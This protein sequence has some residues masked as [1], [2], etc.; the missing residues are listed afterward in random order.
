M[1][2]AKTVALLMG[3]LSKLLAA[4]ERATASGEEARRGKKELIG[5]A[6]GIAEAAEEVTRIAKELAAACTDKRMRTVSSERTDRGQKE[7]QF[8]VL[9][10]E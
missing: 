3:R 7:I 1:A 8:T 6:K 10:L 9:K 2:A 5:A 4:S